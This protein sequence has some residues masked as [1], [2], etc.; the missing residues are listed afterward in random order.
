MRYFFNTFYALFIAAVVLVGGL[1]LLSMM[2]VRT[3]VEAKIVQSGSM[4]PAIPV[5]ALVFITS[6]E[7]Y[8]A[9]DI[10]TFGSRSGEAV[11]TTHRVLDV[12]TENGKTWYATKG[13]AN[14]AADSREVA[15]SEV[16]GKVFLTAP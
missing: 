13:D 5:G 9:G 2:P 6:S 7:H 12:R 3:G 10:I 16:L 8:R 4:S 14:E 1:F 11:P 15:K